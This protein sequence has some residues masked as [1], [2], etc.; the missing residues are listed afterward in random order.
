MPL[1]PPDPHLALAETRA[2]VEH[3]VIGLNLCPFAK[4]VQVKGLL[5]YALSDA[6]DADGLAQALRDEL[7]L[8]QL[9]PCL[10][11]T[12]RTMLHDRKHFGA[13]LRALWTARDV[14][15]DWS[16]PWPF[17]G[18]PLTSLPI[19]RES[20]RRGCTFGEVATLD[21]GWYEGA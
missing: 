16:D 12:Q 17:V 9:Y 19:I 2:W 5:R 11:E 15:W 20:I 18:M 10:T 14:T 8:Q 7:L 13:N 21:V 1:P 6:T 3:A 4:A